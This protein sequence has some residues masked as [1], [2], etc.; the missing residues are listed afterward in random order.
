MATP[1]SAGAWL[2]AE[3]AGVQRR[4]SELQRGRT[5]EVAA[6]AQLAEAL[7]GARS[8]RGDAFVA[9]EREELRHVVSLC[10]DEVNRL[11][12]LHAEI[13]TASPDAVPLEAQPLVIVTRELEQA[14]LKQ[15][16]RVEQRRIHRAAFGAACAAE[17]RAVGVLERLVT[18]LEEVYALA[19]R[20][21]SELPDGEALREA[22][23]LAL[24][25][26]ILPVGVN[27][28]SGVEVGRLEQGSVVR[29][30]GPCRTCTT[31]VVV[32][33]IRQMRFRSTTWKP[34]PL[35]HVEGPVLSRARAS[36]G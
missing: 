34:S 26:S 7:E 11:H 28:D 6:L 3:S 32:Q 22:V 21:L 27:V 25:R 10:T 31:E 19:D 14:L 17:A 23:V 29:P 18:T 36:T 15:Q 9:L 12:G 33:A 2:A 8:R 16:P 4:L 30:S 24:A 20:R 13:L 35:T 5:A 1:S